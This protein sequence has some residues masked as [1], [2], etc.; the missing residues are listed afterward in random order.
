M[1]KFLIFILAQT[2]IF[3]NGQIAESSSAKSRELALG[4]TTLSPCLTLTDK[5]FKVLFNT[6][7]GA[8]SGL[9]PVLSRRYDRLTQDEIDYAKNLLIRDIYLARRIHPV[10]L[11]G[12]NIETLEDVVTYLSK[13][14]HYTWQSLP[15]QRREKFLKVIEILQKY[16]PSFI[17]RRY[18][19]T[20]ISSINIGGSLVEF[21]SSYPL[22][23]NM[24]Y[25]EDLDVYVVCDTL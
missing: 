20:A 5:E 24:P 7:T 10:Y 15:Q 16:V 17:R 9:V 21:W 1:S 4:K 6:Q 23:K 18:P 8:D 19:D 3:G 13:Y 25:G 14:N 2:I 11:A 22:E 12:D